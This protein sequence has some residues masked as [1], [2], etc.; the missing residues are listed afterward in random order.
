MPGCGL[1]AFGLVSF[2]LGL[3]RLAGLGFWWLAC[4]L[5][6][7]L[8][9]LVAACGSGLLG[10]LAVAL[11]VCALWSGFWVCPPSR[12]LFVSFCRWVVACFVFP[13]LLRCS[14]ACLPACLLVRRRVAPL[15]VCPRGGVPG[16]RARVRP[17]FCLFGLFACWVGC[18]AVGRVLRAFSVLRSPC[19]SACWCW[20][21]PLLLACESATY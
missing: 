10:G 13:P 19:S 3:A 16:L 4:C 7:S 15:F 17:F 9:L 6:G 8:S 2:G 14:P 21:A 5:V 18:C 1:A 11:F 20:P 12:S